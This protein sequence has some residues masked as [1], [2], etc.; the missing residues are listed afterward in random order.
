MKLINQGYF[1]VGF[2]FLLTEDVQHMIIALLHYVADGF[3]LQVEDCIESQLLILN[4]LVGGFLN[5][6]IQ[7]LKHLINIYIPLQPIVEDVEVLH[8]GINFPYFPPEDFP[9]QLISVCNVLC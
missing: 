7:G 9:P 6:D 1:Q 4:H 8:L 5:H 2:I 3:F